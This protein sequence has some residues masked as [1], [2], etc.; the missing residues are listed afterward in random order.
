MKSKNKK[1]KRLPI[2]RISFIIDSNLIPEDELRDLYY[3]MLKKSIP[4]TIDNK[5]HGISIPRTVEWSTNYDL[6]T[7]VHSIEFEMEV[8]QENYPS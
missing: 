3:K 7:I 4:M 6:K 2:K 8:D 1:Y 5:I